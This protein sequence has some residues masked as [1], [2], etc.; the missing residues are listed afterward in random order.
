MVLVAGIDLAFS[1]FLSYI[2]ADKGYNH[3]CDI[4]LINV[5]NHPTNQPTTQCRN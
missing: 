1:V 4:L 3:G 2:W 5:E